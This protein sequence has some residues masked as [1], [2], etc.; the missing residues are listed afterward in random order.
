MDRRLPV[1]LTKYP[2]KRGPNAR[3]VNRHACVW[4]IDA[5]HFEG[6]VQSLMYDWWRMLPAVK[7][8]VKPSN[9]L[10]STNHR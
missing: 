3:P 5:A 2:G 8:P 7:E 4:R 9:T 6:G 1:H 10:P